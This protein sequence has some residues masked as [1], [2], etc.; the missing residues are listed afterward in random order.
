MK[1]NNIII[2]IGQLGLQL[3]EIAHEVNEHMNFGYRSQ[4]SFLIIIIIII[5]IFCTELKVVDNDLLKL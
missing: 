3:V 1:A 2:T 5:F 4:I